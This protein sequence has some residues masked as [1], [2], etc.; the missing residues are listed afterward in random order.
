MGGEETDGAS[1]PASLA[2]AEASAVGA[3]HVLQQCGSCREWVRGM[4]RIDMPAPSRSPVLVVL[5][6]SHQCWSG[7]RVV[8]SGSLSVGK[9]TTSFARLV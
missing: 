2:T 6:G 1:A 4:P 7:A 3:A 5:S 9:R 8:L